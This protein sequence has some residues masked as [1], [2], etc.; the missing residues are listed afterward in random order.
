MRRTI[1]LVALFSIALTSL[2]IAQPAGGPNQRGA[3]EP[4]VVVRPPPPPRP[5]FNWDSTGWTKLGERE[6]N[7]RVDKDRIQVGR[8]EGKFSKLTIVVRDSDL[9][10]LDFAV[11]FARGPE[12]RPQVQHYFRENQRTRVID[13]P[14]DDRV[15]KYIDIKYRN[16]A[17]GGRAKVEVW[18]FQGQ[19]TPPPP[20]RPV[21]VSWDSTGWTKLGERD[22]NG[23][24]DTDRIDVGRYEGKFSKLTVVV[25]D[26]D[27]EMIDFAVKFARGPEWRPTNIAHYFRENQRTRAIDFPGDER[28][29]KHIDFKYRNLPGGGRAKVEVWGFKTDNAANNAPNPGNAWDQRGWTMLGERTVDGR[30]RGDNDRVEVGRAEGKFRKLTVVVLDSSLDMQGIEIKFGRGENFRPEVRQVF[31]EGSRTRVIDLPGDDRVI[32]WIDFKYKNLPGGGKA[33][34]QVWAR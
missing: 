34:V 20:P 1:S 27:L 25:R 19:A 7:G 21:V 9:E 29:I 18:G 4:P 3:V 10:M 24:V 5:T 8:Y 15:I 31:N 2:A 13:V 16:L 33:R 32:K 26:S 30:R 23:R 17:G 11:K 6:V 14:G 12:W 22:V 28:S